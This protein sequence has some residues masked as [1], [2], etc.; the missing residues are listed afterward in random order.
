MFQTTPEAFGARLQ[1]LRESRHVT[2]A[3]LAEAVGVNSSYIW[4]IE[5]ENRSPTSPLV[6]KLASALGVPIQALFDES[7]VA[8]SIGL[9]RVDIPLV[10]WASMVDPTSTIPMEVIPIPSSW[11]DSEH[12]PHCFAEV[13]TS[14][15]AQRGI[16]KGSLVL[17]SGSGKFQSGQIAVFRLGDQI[18]IAGATK[19]PEGSVGIEF[20]NES[21]VIPLDVVKSDYFQ[22]IGPVLKV[23]TDPEPIV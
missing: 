12:G 15:L 17:V 7:P 9:V 20:D 5:K 2:R 18:V 3:Q 21:R 13:P 23:I 6:A 10:P 4:R 11:L 22:V 19:N 14:N 16:P 8:G 1:A